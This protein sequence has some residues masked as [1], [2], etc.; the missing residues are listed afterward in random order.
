VSH[1]WHDHVSLEMS[2]ERP[3]PAPPCPRC[4]VG[5]KVKAVDVAFGPGAFIKIRPQVWCRRLK[6]FSCSTAEC[7]C[8]IKTHLSPTGAS[9]DYR[10][11]SICKFYVEE[12][13]T[14][15]LVPKKA[16]RA[17]A[18]YS[19]FPNNRQEFPQGEFITGIQ[20]IFGNSYF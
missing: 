20:K 10:D 5:G 15:I 16:Y 17:A 14:E 2:H 13:M 8:F 18:K 12:G 1:E 6:P 4:G 19:G 11:N 7:V 9:F 3:S